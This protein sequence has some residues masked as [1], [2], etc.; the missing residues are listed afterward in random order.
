ME[1]IETYL[2]ERISVLTDKLGQAGR[3]FLKIAKKTR[4]F[5]NVWVPKNAII[6]KGSWLS[7]LIPFLTF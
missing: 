3:V 5:G 1:P 2:H 4:A 7:F 6:F